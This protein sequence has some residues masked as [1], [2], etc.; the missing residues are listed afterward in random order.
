MQRD[1]AAAE[2]ANILIACAA[3]DRLSPDVLECSH[4]RFSSDASTEDALFRRRIA[5]DKPATMHRGRT[6]C[7][8]AAGKLHSI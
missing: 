7:K 3:T 6:E 8:F 5:I 4:G 1:E 2:H